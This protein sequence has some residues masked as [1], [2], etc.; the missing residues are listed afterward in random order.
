MRLQKT[1]LDFAPILE[2]YQLDRL[3]KTEFLRAL[4]NEY[5]SQYQRQ[6]VYTALI[7]WV[8]YSILS[9]G[10]FAKVLESSF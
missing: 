4:T 10:Y 5:W 1:F 7:P 2:N 8:I 6:I 3:Y 9:L